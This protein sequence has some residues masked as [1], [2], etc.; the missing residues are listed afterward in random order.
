MPNSNILLLRK[1]CFPAF[2]Q[3][4]VGSLHLYGR[5]ILWVIFGLLRPICM[6][7]APR[8]TDGMRGVHHVT[9]HCS[10][11]SIRHLCK[12]ICARGSARYR[13]IF[14]CLRLKSE[15]SLG[16]GRSKL[17]KQITVQLCTALATRGHH[18]VFRTDSGRAH[19]TVIPCT[20]FGWRGGL[21][22]F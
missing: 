12:C 17:R 8:I 5:C 13:T 20:R 9:P 2:F 3:E 11:A 21:S 22:A 1:Y 7:D 10:A 16:T 18:T 19:A 14:S 4:T 6:T 15:A